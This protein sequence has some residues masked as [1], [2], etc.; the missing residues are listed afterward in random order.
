MQRAIAVL[1]AQCRFRRLCR[2]THVPLIRAIKSMQDSDPRIDALRVRDRDDQAADAQQQIDAGSS[3]ALTTTRRSMTSCAMPWT[4]TTT[5][6]SVKGSCPGCA[7]QKLRLDL[8]KTPVIHA[9]AI[10]DDAIA[11][12]RNRPDRR[13]LCD[14][15]T[16]TVS[17][18]A[19]AGCRR[20]QRSLPM[21]LD[22]MFEGVN[23]PMRV[24][25][26]AQRP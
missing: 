5:S 24:S 8:G 20:G 10:L 9:Q 2:A 25:T 4:T 14:G 7:L 19:T 11:R 12:A 3:R 16:S 26:E 6:T 18:A 15:P 21:Q 22:N 13:T 17:S 1:S 23:D